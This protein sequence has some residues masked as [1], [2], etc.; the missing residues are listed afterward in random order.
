MDFLGLGEFFVCGEVANIFEKLPFVSTF[1]IY[2]QKLVWN[3]RN[4]LPVHK[5]LLKQETG[6]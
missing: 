3:A 6:L 1:R 4:T 2:V 5:Q